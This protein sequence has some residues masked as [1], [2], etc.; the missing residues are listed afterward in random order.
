V[1]QNH[2]VAQGEHLSKIAAEYGFTDY[3]LIWNDAGN[4]RLKTLRINPN[5]LLPGDSLYIPDKQQGN[6]SGATSKRH[7]FQVNQKQ[8][9][10][11]LILEDMYEKPISN[12]PALLY[13]NQQQVQATT[14]G[15]GKIDQPIPSGVQSC[16]I[17]LN[18]EATP[19]QGTSF[20]VKIGHL[21]PVDTLTGQQG[22]LN[23]LGYLAGSSTDP[24][25]P[26]FL[27]AVEEF[28]C[29]HDLKVDGAL[30]PATQTKLKSIHGC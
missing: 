9:R 29:D 12:E 11:R 7:S 26:Q 5:V 21:D 14:D 16:V 4:A 6:A 20:P 25:D 15:Q 18:S 23:N 27:S 13:L 3:T 17:V 2:V 8:L 24:A 22:R 30:G 10:L 19:H 28:Q 1:A